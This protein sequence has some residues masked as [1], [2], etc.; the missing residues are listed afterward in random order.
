MKIITK[1][2]W[3]NHWVEGQA[4]GAYPNGS[5]VRKVMGEPG[6]AHPVGSLATVISSMSGEQV[7]LDRVGIGYFVEWDA[8]PKAAVLVVAAKLALA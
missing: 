5:R 1:P 4:P 6:D 2:G 3:R 7:G 8:S